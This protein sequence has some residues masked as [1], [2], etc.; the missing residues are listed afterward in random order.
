MSRLSKDFAKWD[1]LPVDK[2]LLEVVKNE[3]NFEHVTKV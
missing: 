3:L 2:T 1:D